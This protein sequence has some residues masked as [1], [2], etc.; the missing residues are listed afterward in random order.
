M[1]CRAMNMKSILLPH[2]M[3]TAEFEFQMD[4]NYFVVLR[5]THLALK[6]KLVRGRDYGTYNT[7][8]QIKK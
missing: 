8:Q 2:L 1:S 5:Q 4:W 6:L 7:N 3:K